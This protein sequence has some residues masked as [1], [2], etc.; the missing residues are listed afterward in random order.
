MLIWVTRMC[1]ANAKRWR[2]SMC[3][4]LIDRSARILT[5]T[6]EFLWC[7]WFSQKIRRQV[8]FFV[9]RQRCRYFCV[10]FKIIKSDRKINLLKA[11]PPWLYRGD[12]SQFF[13]KEK[14]L[15][16]KHSIVNCMCNPKRWRIDTSILSYSIVKLWVY[17]QTRIWTWGKQ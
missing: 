8:N 6:I 14:L 3:Y 4:N 5:Q 12:C 10:V 16:W 1:C 7:C 9:L 11:I 2:V 15:C 13:K 17:C